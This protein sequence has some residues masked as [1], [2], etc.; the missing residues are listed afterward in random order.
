MNRPQIVG[1]AF[2]IVSAVLGAIGLANTRPL[3]PS[4]KLGALAAIDTSNDGRISAA[5]WRAAGRDPA[6][7]A[8]LDKNHDG[9]LEPKEV[10]AGR[11][12]GGPR[13]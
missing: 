10:K 13:E 12:S 11:R 9:M 5:E 7:M 2:A 1:M 3:P 4:A 8:K 6:A